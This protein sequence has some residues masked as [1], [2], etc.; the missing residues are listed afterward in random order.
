[1]G[2]GDRLTALIKLEDNANTLD[3]LKRLVLFFDHVQYIMPEMSP[4]ITE[5]LESGKRFDE[6][7]FVQKRPDGSLDVSQFNYFRDTGKYFQATLD[8]LNP[9][10]RESILEFEEA[11]VVSDSFNSRSTERTEQDKRFTEIKNLI[12]YADVQDEEFVRLSGTKPEDFRMFR[13]LATITMT[14]N[15]K[16]QD[17]FSML[18]FEEPQAITDSLQLS[19]ILYA[20]HI[21]GHC[22]IF[23]NT[24]HRE[25]IRYRYEQ[26]LE[27]LQIVQKM[28]KQLVSPDSFV[29]RFGEVTFGVAN[30]AFSSEI[31][32]TKRADDILRYRNSMDSSRRKYISTDLMDL[33]TLAKDN[34]WDSR[35]KEEL[36]KYIAGKLNHDLAILDD[37]AQRVWD[38]MFGS[39]AV[40]LS[41]VGRSGLVGGGAAGIVGQLIPNATTWELVIVGAIAGLAKESPKMVQTLVD[42]FIDFRQ[43][44]RNA[45][46][47]LANFR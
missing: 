12:A 24:R 26:F 41:E 25:E 39:I 30:A 15:S 34:P 44:K 45:I 10:L 9:E 23:L 14:G 8:N 6:L 32:R 36:S 38:K 47:Y 7:S 46:S 13:N 42:S 4:I 27:G 33:T 22:P 17:T 40:R 18:T 29:G 20:S 11:G 37:E 28:D 3:Q 16:P 2:K 1:M 21:S 43:R 19:D 31:I 5:S 35:L